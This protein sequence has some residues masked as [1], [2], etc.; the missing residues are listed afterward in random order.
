MKNLHNVLPTSIEKFHADNLD[1]LF[2]DLKKIIKSQDIILF[3]GSRA[4]KL[5]KIINKFK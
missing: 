3:K 5:D 4:M 2:V 1:E